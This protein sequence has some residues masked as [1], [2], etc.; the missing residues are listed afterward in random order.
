M[1]TPITSQEQGMLLA[2]DDLTYTTVSLVNKIN[3][4]IE[5]IN[6]EPDIDEQILKNEIEK[7]KCNIPN[8]PFCNECDEPVDYPPIVME[9][10]EKIDLTEEYKRR[11]LKPAG[12]V[13]KA[14][15]DNTDAAF[16]EFDSRAYNLELRIDEIK[17]WLNLQVDSKLIKVELAIWLETKLNELEEI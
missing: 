11:G 14:H 7:K 3:E 13:Y 16:D 1:I 2:Y 12:D 10:S 9:K 6:G 4:I 5:H 8:C 15:L 17:E